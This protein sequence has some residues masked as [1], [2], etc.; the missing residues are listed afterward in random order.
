M[1][2]SDELSIACNSCP[3][4]DWQ[5]G[6]ESRKPR[7][8]LVMHLRRR[9]DLPHTLWKRKFYRKH[10]R[11]PQPDNTTDKSFTVQQ[12]ESLLQKVFCRQ[13]L[14]IIDLLDTNAEP[15]LQSHGVTGG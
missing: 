12:A 5:A 9:S 13:S 15:S 2:R 4:C 1:P 7:A 11:D 3:V 8:A 10:S 14:R 6:A